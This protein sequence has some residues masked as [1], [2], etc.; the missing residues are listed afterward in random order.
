MNEYVR[1]DVDLLERASALLIKHLREQEGNEVLL[2]HDYFWSIPAS[3]ANDMN[4]APVGLTVGQVTECVDW[5][6]DILQSPENALTYHLVWLGEVMRA[7]G[8]KA[9]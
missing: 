6:R 1:I 4:T 2:D 3:Q 8:H 5:L 7:V 9:G